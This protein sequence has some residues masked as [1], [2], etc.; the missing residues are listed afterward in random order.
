M[1][2]D[3]LERAASALRETTRDPNP[4]AGLTRARL[5]ASAERRYAPRRLF[6]MRWL[7]MCA[8]LLV[9]GTAMAAQM[10]GGL[11]ELLQAIA[12]ALTPAPSPP[13]RVKQ[14]P[15]PARVHGPAPAPRSEPASI[16]IEPSIPAPLEAAPPADLPPP[17]IPAP[18]APRPTPRPRLKP[19]PLALPLALPNTKPNPHSESSASQSPAAVPAPPPPAS[20]PESAELALFRRA[21]RLHRAH[22]PAALAAWDAYL[23]VAPNGALAPEAHYNRALC[24]VRL[25]RVADASAALGPFARGELHGYRQAE[26]RALLEGLTR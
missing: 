2:D 21:E 8:T 15:R 19:M 18:H 9:G 25:G 14:P 11:P 13:P 26:A 12:P 16:A 1:S 20:A 4:R 24:L 5:L 7:L 17:T 3:L 22:D 6:A 10:A 23:R